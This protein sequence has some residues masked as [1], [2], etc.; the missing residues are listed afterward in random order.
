[1]P[2]STDFNDFTES[3]KSQDFSTQPNQ[4]IFYSRELVQE[5]DENGNSFR[6]TE[7]NS[8]I[9]RELANEH[10]FQRIEDTLGGKWLNAQN[11]KEFSE[12]QQRV[13]WSIA[14]EKFTQQASGNVSAVIVNADKDR[15]FYQTEFPL[16][17]KGDNI[18]SINGIRTDELRQNL[19]ISEMPEPSLKICFDKVSDPIQFENHIR[20]R[21]EQVEAERQQLIQ[22]KEK[23][24]QEQKMQEEKSRQQQEQDKREE[25]I[26]R[27]AQ[28][29]VEK[30]K[31]DVEQK[32]Q[33]KVNEDKQYSQQREKEQEEQ[34]RQ[35]QE[36]AKA[37]QQL[38][39]EHEQQSS[40]R[41]SHGHS[42]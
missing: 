23:A 12:D 8:L 1:V 25:Q 9:A 31:F 14:S 40:Q 22:Q 26:Q 3:V 39:K 7:L 13:I 34:A 4:A 30:E 24:S 38:S 27:Q 20:E 32:I 17:V 42:Y 5:I 29:Q 36:Q 37:E 21:T 33:A 2:Q 6:N 41:Y 18:T 19:P 15:V 28:E 11:L 35:K 10:G 16:L